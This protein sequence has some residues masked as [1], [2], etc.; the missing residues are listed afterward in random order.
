MR[1][2]Y[3]TI[4]KLATI[5]KQEIVFLYKSN[6]PLKFIYDKFNITA[7]TLYI[8]LREY[9]IKNKSEATRLKIDQIENLIHDYQYSSMTL[10]AIAK[11][12]N[13]CEATIIHFLNIYAPDVP[14]RNKHA[15]KPEREQKICTSYKNGSGISQLM[16]THGLTEAQITSILVKYGLEIR[17]ECNYTAE[18]ILKVRKLRSEGFTYKEIAK[19]IGRSVQAIGWLCRKIGLTKHNKPFYS[20]ELKLKAKNLLLSGMSGTA[21][22]KQLGLRRDRVWEWAKKFGIGLR[23]AKSNKILKKF[24]TTDK[25]M[26]VLNARSCVI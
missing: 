6:K 24:S 21:V 20:Q 13:V 3:N 9:G 19:R 22:A 18:Q 5:E 10:L 15:I 8:I 16:Y 12:Y 1:K 2:T 14:K 11:K 4:H 7:P 23:A 17:N 26:E 25:I